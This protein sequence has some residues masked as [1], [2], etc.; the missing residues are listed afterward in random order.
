MIVNK[1]R[2]IFHGRFFII[3]MREGYQE[4]IIAEIN[5][6]D[7]TFT[8][9]HLIQPV[10]QSLITYTFPQQFNYYASPPWFLNTFHLL[11]RKN[12]IRAFITTNE[13]F[14]HLN[15][16]PFILLIFHF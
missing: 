8:N 12:E 3:F 10:L 15:L 1:P 6:S 16:T 2:S 5:D 14:L 13:F 4:V 9:P 11:L 7:N